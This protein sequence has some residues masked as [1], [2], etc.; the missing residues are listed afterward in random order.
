MRSVDFLIIGQGI[1]GTV[2]S[3]WAQR[4]GFSVHVVDEVSPN[5]ASTVAGGLINP[6]T[7]RFFRKSWLFDELLPEIGL[8]Y[9]ALEQL[10]DIS[11]WHSMPLYRMLTT[12]QELNDWELCRM[13]P[14]YEGY[15]GGPFKGSD[16]RLQQ[17]VALAPVWEASWL[18]TSV[19]IN[20]YRVYLQKHDSFTEASFQVSSLQ[21]NNWND[22][23]FKHLIMC[24]GFRDSV[25]LL[26]PNLDLRPAKG[27]VMIVEIEGPDLEYILNKNMLL[28]P[29]GNK[30]YKVG[31]T[32]EHTST[33]SLLP[34]SLEELKI[35]LES[36]IQAPYRIV[37]RFS[38]VRPTVKDRRPLLGVSTVQDNVYIMNGLGAKGVS[39]AP[40]FA[41]H[42]LRHITEGEPIMQ[43]VNWQRFA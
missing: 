33:K 42:L 14:G 29:L 31:A 19:L 8:T 11:C 7:G 17:H 39:L 18:N 21:R 40:F 41:K 16:E 26:F 12:Q 3:F 9:Q 34:G 15:M 6:I 13:I 36:V 5:S 27:E 32:F 23:T 25:Q 35:K 38:G 37:E 2:F 22:I 28:I 10:L 1:A 20:A 24:Q 30:L 43:E 4:M